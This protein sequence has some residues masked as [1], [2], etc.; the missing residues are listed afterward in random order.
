MDLISLL[1][2][3]PGLT[4]ANSH[5]VE[6]V[7]I[8]A[9]SIDSRQVKPGSLFVALDGARFDG[10]KFLQDAARAGAAALLVDSA[11]AAE[12]QLDLPLLQAENTRQIL[13]PL[14]AEF[15]RHP[16]DELCLVG[17]TGTNG[18]T[19]ITW[20][21]D[22]IF[23]T[24]APKKFEQD[25]SPPRPRSGLMGTIEYRWGERR[26][27][28]NNTTPESL[29]VQRILRRMRDDRVSHVA[30]EVSSHG[31]STHRLGGAHFDV[32]IFSNFT[33]DHLDFHG[34]MERYREAKASLFTSLLPA[35]GRAGKEPCAV[36]NLDDPA[37]AWFARRARAAGVRTVTYGSSAAAYWR[38][39]EVQYSLDGTRFVIR[40]PSDSFVVDSPLMGAFNVSNVLA[41][42][43]A[44]REVGISSAQIRAGLRALKQ[45]PGRMQRVLP[46][47]EHARARAPAVLVD[48]AH[49]PDALERAL[50]TVRELT[51]GRVFVVF[52][53]GGDR[54]RQKRAPMGQ[55]AAELA[56]IALITSDNPRNEDPDAII[57]DILRGVELA[58]PPAQALKAAELSGASKG[59]FTQED[60]ALAIKA[61]IQSAG[62][63]DVLLIAG[64]GHET[65]QERGGSRVRFDDVEQAKNSLDLKV[66][67][68]PGRA[69]D[70]DFDPKNIVPGTSRISTW[71]LEKIAKTVGGEL[72]FLDP[73]RRLEQP[74]FTRRPK[75]VSSDSRTLKPGE[76][77]VA[78]RGPNFDAHELLAGVTQAAALMVDTLEGIESELPLILVEDTLAGLTRLGHAIW[79]EAT[80]SGLHTTN[81][82]GSNGKTTV[83]EM[84]TLLRRPDGEVFATPGNLNNH[85]G[86]PLVLCA[87]PYACD[88]LVLELGANAPGEISSLL[89]LAPGTQRIITSIGLAHIEGFGSLGGVRRAK[90]EVFERAT[91]ETLAVVPFSEADE[92]LPLD[93]P[94][95]VRTVGFEAGADFRV[96][97]L[98]D[99]PKEQGVAQSF[100]IHYDKRSLKIKLPIPG[101]HHAL[102]AATALAARVE[103]RG[104]KPQ[105]ETRALGEAEFNELFAQLR[106]PAGRWREVEAGGIQFIDDAYN[107]NPSSALASVDA[108]LGSPNPDS[109]PLVVILGE[110]RE[111]GEDAQK[112]HAEIAKEIA[113][114]PGL[115]ALITVGEFAEEMAL[116]AGSSS[117]R[118]EVIGLADPAAA[119]R[120]LVEF[121][122]RQRPPMV[123][124]KASR[125]A[126]LESVIDLV[127]KDKER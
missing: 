111:L 109:R 106:L 42:A 51:T 122:R 113:A 17:V 19:T 61:A 66:S 1:N 67:K 127:L 60:R 13:G 27:I 97:L 72:R 36:I 20:I 62:A 89:Q 64:K 125:G 79:Q 108:F 112:I 102:N 124:L 25:P 84:L 41:A 71:T 54:D 74:T 68:S 77:F 88:H 58:S 21:L 81:I 8:S 114:R 7:E 63:D 16:S 53:C 4:R 85:I 119:A 76:L 117:A 12:V 65:Y 33:Q 103:G 55:I 14:A 24:P 98:E 87:L 48:Y 92:L 101:A 59:Y 94:G 50:S 6:G 70:A 30:M 32:A 28:A 99:S 104:S 15:F 22:A 44:A 95:R 116:S 40:G 49:T 11:R 83:K 86:V 126:R 38:A 31:L 118:T 56:D 78:L 123:L 69:P 96:E 82:T 18:K 105:G 26:E 3:V 91:P 9:I 2:R 29:V 47:D 115:S 34:D 107:A 75:G 93:F 90:A 45:V 73:A 100:Y 37:G 110:M 120:W 52:G 43:A 121:S 10:H 80:E 46:S 57:T 23:S 5:A 39:D 35:A